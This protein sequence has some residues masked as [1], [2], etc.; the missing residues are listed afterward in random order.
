MAYDNNN[1]GIMYRNKRREK[2][3]HPEFTGQLTVDGVEY[4]LSAWVNE[5]KPGSKMEGQKYFKLLFN[6]KDVQRGTASNPPPALS[7]D[8]L[9]DIPF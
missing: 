6:P 3:T 5:G 1:S 8:D 7:M 9:D 2:D 4:W